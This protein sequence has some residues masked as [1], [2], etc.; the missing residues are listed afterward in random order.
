MGVRHGQDVH[1]AAQL[2]EALLVAHAKALLL[3][4]DHQAQILKGHVRR[5]EPVGADDD[6]HRAAL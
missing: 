4:D 1:L 2:L 5:E 6:I 3:V